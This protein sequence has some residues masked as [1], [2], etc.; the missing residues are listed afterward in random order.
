MIQI[1]VQLTPRDLRPMRWGVASRRR[2]RWVAALAVLVFV[3]VTSRQLWEVPAFVAFVLAAIV[4]VNQLV[5]RRAFRSNA[6]LRGTQ[7]W[8]IDESG[9]RYETTRDDGEHVGEGRYEW[10]AVDRVVDARDAFLLFVSARACM[11]LP[12]R[13][14]ASD[15]EMERLRALVAAHGP[16]RS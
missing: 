8:T 6:Q 1:S 13:C 15:A 3:T 7:H 16:A 4:G 10:R 11:I 2:G 14:F 9:L 12:K 5:V